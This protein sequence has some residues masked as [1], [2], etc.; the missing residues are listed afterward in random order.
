M[1]LLF[2]VLFLEGNAHSSDLSFVTEWI[3]SADGLSL[4]P[5]TRTIMEDKLS[6][7]IIEQSEMILKSQG[8]ADHPVYINESYRMAVE[9]TAEAAVG[10]LVG[11]KGVELS[12]EASNVL[13]EFATELAIQNRVAE[14]LGFSSIQLKE[15]SLKPRLSEQV[16]VSGDEATLMLSI[17]QKPVLMVDEGHQDNYEV[18][19][20]MNDFDPQFVSD[21]GG[22]GSGNGLIER[23]EWV[24]FDVKVENNSSDWWFSS[25]IWFDSDSSCVWFPESQEMELPELGP[26]LDESQILKQTGEDDQAVEIEVIHT[27]KSSATIPL[28]LYVS[29]ECDLSETVSIQ[30]TIKDTYRTQNGPIQGEIEI[31]VSAF[32]QG[33]LSNLVL[34]SD[35]PGAS[36][37][38]AFVE[39]DSKDSIEMFSEYTADARS[40]DA[41]MQFMVEGNA[42]K[43]FKSINEV[44]LDANDKE[45]EDYRQ[46]L[47]VGETEQVFQTVPSV[48]KE[49][50]LGTISLLRSGGEPLDGSES[51]VFAPQDDLDLRTLTNTQSFQDQVRKLASHWEWTDLDHAKVLWA[52][53][54]K[55]S[56]P[57]PDEYSPFEPIEPDGK[58]DQEPVDV[59]DDRVTPA[60]DVNDIIELLPDFL[61]ISAHHIDS[62]DG[63]TLPF[64][65][66][67][68]TKSE[69][70][71]DEIETEY[72]SRPLKTLDA[73]DAT[74]FELDFDQD[75]FKTAYSNLIKLPPL[76]QVEAEEAPPAPETVENHSLSYV[77]RYYFTVPVK[78]VL[79]EE[80]R[81]ECT[82]RIDNDLDGLTD[83]EELVCQE[84]SVCQPKER[85]FVNDFGYSSSR[86]AI[87]N[88]TTNE[89]DI[90]VAWD[91][92][93]TRMRGF[94]YT[95]S[96]GGPKWRNYWSFSYMG[97]H[98]DSEYDY[99]AVFRYSNFGTGLQR[100]FNSGNPVEFYTR[101][102]YSIQNFTVDIDD[103]L[104]F[105]GA[106]SPFVD[107]GMYFYSSEHFGGFAQLSWSSVET[108]N[109][110]LGDP[111]SSS[112]AILLS[113]GV[114]AKSS[115]LKMPKY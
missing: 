19:N 100:H 88:L 27:H 99:D 110:S 23:G 57:T 35:L 63:E 54:V 21:N 95:A 91:K 24:S 86:V 113:I 89:E 2:A 34:D 107:L 61:S 102:G 104:G 103:S 109:S 16:S 94:T 83:C 36:K 55:I 111:V 79:R 76:E 26:T 1:S 105:R 93:S 80:T 18:V 87:N 11:L 41:E 4:A 114:S 40:T 3:E 97:G 10:R 60:A 12:L 69:D 17:Q 53:D 45:I 90:A 115:W 46:V 101:A 77:Y 38:D 64:E 47:T 98:T 112:G 42:Q 59:A 78:W 37:G 74:K 51:V 39:L 29:S 58:S 14:H 82:D 33:H 50:E 49:L 9:S 52:V 6:A 70:A 13:E 73:I 66:Q 8:I 7:Y 5:D 30:Y 28:R 43:L 48:R 85:F 25:S 20:L 68:I 67:V 84:F 108:V 32:A 106:Y 92:N 65:Q 75:G 81:S 62:N 15:T 22:Y 72:G 31:S 71:E 44:G 56:Y 96:I